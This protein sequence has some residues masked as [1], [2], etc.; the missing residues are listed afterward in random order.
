[1]EYRKRILIAANYFFFILLTGLLISISVSQARNHKAQQEMII[2]LEAAIQDRFDRQTELLA[3]AA[4]E[5]AEL[6]Q[7]IA[8]G[9]EEIMQ[10]MTAGTA[11]MMRQM[12][13]ETQVTGERI[14]GTNVRIQQIDNVYSGLL[15]EQQKR[16]LD[17]LYNES[18]LME[19]AQKAARLF[20]DGDY[21]GASAEYAIIA[22][23]R[24]EDAESQFF[25]WYSLFLNNRM[26]KS[27]YRKIKEG[28]QALERNGY[29][30]AEIREVLEYIATEEEGLPL[31]LTEGFQ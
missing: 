19:K 16:T 2:A 22:Q 29:L 12:T 26:D 1:M 9:T 5:R 14:R 21:M 10:Q 4:M 15:A 11:R 24:P 13:A 23:A 31:D 25:Q 20:Q 3:E 28:L 8:D 17:S 7:Q 27:N 6:A 30:R 18:E